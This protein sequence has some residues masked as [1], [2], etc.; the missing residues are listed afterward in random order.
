MRSFHE[1]RRYKDDFR[2]WL[3]T[4]RNMGFYAHWH[5]EM[6]LIYICDGSACLHIGDETFEAH[7]GDLLLCPSGCI[8][9]SPLQT[10]GNCLSFLLLHP[11]ALPLP[12]EL[13]QYG[14]L[15]LPAA[16]LQQAGLADQ[17]AALF[18]QT[19]AE[20]DAQA[21]HYRMLVQSRLAAFCCLLCRRVPPPAERAAAQPWQNSTMQNMQKALDY[22]S[23][24]F[25][26]PLSLNTVA[27][28]A[29]FSPCHFS[30]LFCRYA[31]IGFAAYL[32]AI[33]VEQAIA[34]LR[35]EELPV[36]EAAFR[37]GFSSIRSFNRA[38]R[39]MTGRS[40]TAFLQNPVPGAFQPVRTAPPSAQ[41]VVE[42]DSYV[43]RLRSTEP[44]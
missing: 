12:S 33:R 19:A 42:Q 44:R 41:P 22:I 3:G 7:Q 20:L 17:T 10:P 31:G 15:H 37:C 38:F 11:R 16:K 9:Y 28:V 14:P 25:F 21:P 43:V 6:E 2:V 4:Y 29:G 24:H 27:A 36:S 18:A 23:A 32:N 34:L 26:E 1:V 5:E 8:H 13:S 30:R 40:P 39:Q 35:A